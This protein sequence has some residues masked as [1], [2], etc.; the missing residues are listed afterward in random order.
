MVD[1]VGNQR[2]ERQRLLVRHLGQQ[3][4]QR[5][6]HGQAHG[7]QH[8]SRLFL[9]GSVDAG[10]DEVIRH[11]WHPP[12]QF[13]LHYHA[14]WRAVRSRR[15]RANPSPRSGPR[16]ANRGECGTHLP[17]ALLPRPHRP[18]DVP[19]GEGPAPRRSASGCGPSR[20]GRTSNPARSSRRSPRLAWKLAEAKAKFSEVVRLAESGR[21]QRVTVRGRD[22]VAVV[23]AAEFDGL[24]ARA[25]PATLHEL[26]AL[27]SRLSE[28]IRL[29]AGGETV[30][31][32]DRDQVVAE[33]GP[34]RQTRGSVSA[35]AMLADAVRKGWV[36]PAL[37]PGS[38]P[39]RGGPP[40]A[41]LRELLRDLEGDRSDR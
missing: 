18:P 30:L 4:P 21:P 17:L 33:I 31:V 1:G 25:R 19:A 24:Q 36:T 20:V 22:A 40:V 39:P 29:A 35:G 9:H 15:H 7:R 27:H 34:P 41:T 10:L 23:G 28:Y 13:A 37:S 14:D 2:R 38:E 32:T 5:A 12:F 26:R 16:W 11:V 6:R 3:Q 8:R